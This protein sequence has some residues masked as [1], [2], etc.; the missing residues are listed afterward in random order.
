MEI[1]YLNNIDNSVKDEIEKTAL[2][3]NF[4]SLDKKIGIFQSVNYDINVPAV[5][6]PREDSEIQ[7]D[8]NPSLREL[9]S[10]FSEEVDLIIWIGKST[11]QDP[12]LKKIIPHEFRHV[13][14][15]VSERESFIKDR[16]LDCLLTTSVAPIERDASYF[17]DKTVGLSYDSSYDWKQETETLF[18]S[19]KDN[20]KELYEALKLGKATIVTINPSQAVDTIRMT[21]EQK[22]ASLH[23]FE[24]AKNHFDN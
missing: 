9:L 20:I 16:A 23:F 14:Q 22:Q 6:I 8:L 5:T 4:V 1:I 13:E 12:D 3:N 21:D 18:L 17:A 15:Q 2:L 10:H 7:A 24:K 19:Q 11:P